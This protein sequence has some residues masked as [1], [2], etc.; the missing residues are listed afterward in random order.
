MWGMSDS[1]KANAEIEARKKEKK[2]RDDFA[3]YYA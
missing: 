2:E 1:K 3:A